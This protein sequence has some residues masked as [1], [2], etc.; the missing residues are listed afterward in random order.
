MPLLTITPELP[1]PIQ[2]KHVR[3][4]CPHC[5]T[6]STLSLSALPD[7]D[8]AVRRGLRE[9]VAGYVCDGCNRAIPLGWHIVHIDGSGIHGGAAWEMLRVREPFEFA[10]VPE[11]VKSAVEEALDCLS[12]GAYNGFAAMCR[13]TIQAS[14]A[15]LGADGS[16]ASR[17]TDQGV[18]GVGGDR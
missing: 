4:R 11:T 7:R 13:R 8:N 10:Y 2:G 17:S 5:G 6:Q 3:F 14:C 1:G 16:L 9:V 12:V 18:E 15:Q